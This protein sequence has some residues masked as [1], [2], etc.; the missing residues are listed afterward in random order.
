MD[1][2]LCWVIFLRAD[3]PWRKLCWVLGLVPQSGDILPRCPWV[4]AQQG[5]RTGWP[6]GGPCQS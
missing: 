3:S 1:M 4:P 5:G 6:F 2:W